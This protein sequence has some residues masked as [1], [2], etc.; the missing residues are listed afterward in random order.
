MDARRVAGCSPAPTANERPRPPPRPRRRRRS[1][2]ARRRRHDRSRL[3]PT[4]G[5]SRSAARGR[6]NRRIGWRRT[7]SPSSAAAQ[8]G[9]QARVVRVASSPRSRARTRAPRTRAAGETCTRAPPRLFSRASP[10]PRRVY[11]VRSIPNRARKIFAADPDPDPSREDASA[12]DAGL[13][14]GSN[15]CAAASASSR[16]ARSA[17]AHLIPGTSHPPRPLVDEIFFGVDG[18]RRGGIRRRVVV[19][20]PAFV[21]IPDVLRAFMQEKIHAS[22]AAIFARVHARADATGLAGNLGTKRLLGIGIRDS[23][24]RIR[25]ESREETR[26]LRGRQRARRLL[27]HLGRTIL[28]CATP[29]RSEVEKTASRRRFRRRRRQPRRLF[30]PGGTPD[31]SGGGSCRV[32]IGDASRR[33]GSRFIFRAE[34]RVDASLRRGRVA[35]RLGANQVHE[36]L[37]LGGWRRGFG[38]RPPSTLRTLRTNAR[39]RFDRFDRFDRFVVGVF[40]RFSVGVVDVVAGRGA[41][42]VSVLPLEVFAVFR[43]TLAPATTGRGTD[44]R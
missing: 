32:T 43:E 5:S 41:E 42:R 8:R 3:R 15:A 37:A 12:R 36:T 26:L 44:G 33:E 4:E 18:P 39:R 22:H 38:R 6:A 35:T 30:K 17:R 28:G 13:S 16:A 23:L 11:G 21:L 31:A 25:V 7:P 24:A 34:E 1:P 27:R 20:A 10:P 29:E 9:R 19:R 40:E 2:L 14:R